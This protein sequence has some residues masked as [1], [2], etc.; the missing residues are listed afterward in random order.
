MKFRFLLTGLCLLC[1]PRKGAWIEIHKFV[2]SAEKSSRPRKGAWIEI[3]L[4]T[5]M[6]YFHWRRPRKGAWIEM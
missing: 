3:R 4:R 1:R 5:S 2:T 6:A